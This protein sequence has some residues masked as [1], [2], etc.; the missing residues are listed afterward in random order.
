MNGNPFSN[1]YPENMSCAQIK[2]LFVDEF[3]DLPNILNHNHHFIWGA[4]GSGKS[5]LFRYIE[6]CCHADSVKELKQQSLI[7]CPVIP[8]YYK[9][10][11]N[12]LRMVEF[13]LIDKNYAA[14]LT[15]HMLIMSIVRLTLNNIKNYED[16]QKENKITYVKQIVYDLFGMDVEESVICANKSR[17][18][19]NEPLEWLDSICQH[20]LNAVLNYL[21][22]THKNIDVDYHGCIVGYHDFLIP[23]F[24]LTK[25]LIGVNNLV[26][27]LLIDEA[28]RTYEF[29]QEIL[30]GW[31]ACRNHDV[32]SIKLTSVR[33]EYITFYTRDRWSIQNTHDFS[34]T[35]LNIVHYSK[36]DYK[37][38]IKKV[39]QKRFIAYGIEIDDIEKFYPIDSTYQ[40]IIDSEKDK[41]EKEYVD[42]KTKETFSEYCSRRLIPK[43]FQY[44]SEKH[45]SPSYSGFEML[46]ATSAGIIR[47]FLEPSEMMY[48][49]VTQQ[50]KDLKVMYIPTNIQEEQINKYSEVFFN[51][52]RNVA[53]GNSQDKNLLIKLENLIRALGKYFRARLLME[54][55]TE[56]RIFSFA[57]KQVEKLSYE[58]RRV[59]QLAEQHDYLQKSFYSGKNGTNAEEWY[60]LSRK[61]APFFKLDPT[62]L[63]GRIVFSPLDIQTAME[64]PDQFVK[65][66]MSKL[67]K[68]KEEKESEIYQMSLFDDEDDI[69]YMEELECE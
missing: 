16:I 44:L 21:R 39:V 40:N 12:T 48:D 25:D 5:M 69:F 22:S 35:T 7:E 42:C 51:S 56:G 24:E 31:I 63:K 14:L 8:I 1:R 58:E 33:A 11:S 23:F 38:K 49:A 10:A 28:G 61:L 47:N 55:L 59:L 37:R 62:A 66:K 32:L 15:E 18:V 27:Y 20:E 30:N 9:I 36:E 41:L 52:I 6:A 68:R 53:L 13:V 43:V 50:N 34:E 54:D 4:R 26:F 64:N 3:V 45:K 46:V 2:E 17:V 19:E 65:M 29:Q 60:L 67:Q 57:I